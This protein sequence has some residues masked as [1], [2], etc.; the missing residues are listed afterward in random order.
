MINEIGT[1]RALPNGESLFVGSSSGVF[2]INTVR[3]AFSHA[4]GASRRRSLNDDTN[5]SLASLPSPE[6][7]IFGPESYAEAA[8]SRPTGAPSDGDGVGELPS[9]TVAKELLITYF[10]IWHPLLPFLHGPSCL[11]ELEA[12]Y[13]GEADSQPRKPGSLSMA[14][15]L[16]CLFNIAKLDRPDLPP[17]GRS[18]IGSEEQLLFSLSTLSL[19]RD[20]T[21]IQ[22]LL[23]A[24]L[25]FVAT[26]SLQAASTTGGLVLRSIFKSGLHRCPFRYSTF[27]A[28]DRDMRK[29]VI[30]SA[31]T[32]DRYTSQSLGHPLG[33]QDSDIDVCPPGKIELHKPVFSNN[34]MEEGTSLEESILHLPANHPQRQTC[35]DS[36]QVQ[37]QEQLVHERDEEQPIES[38]HS[39]NIEVESILQRR[40]RNQ[41]VQAQFVRYSRLVGR[42]IEMFHKSIHVRSVSRQDILFL[43]A[44]I[45]AWGNDMPY[46]EFAGLNPAMTPDA[47]SS[48]L[49]QD[50]FF[51]VARQQLLLLVNR[52]SLS[53]EP[54]SAEF[55][56]AVQICIGA[57][58]SIIRMLEAHFNLRETLFWPG[59]MSAVWMSG[60]VM[61]FACQLKL[62]SISNAIRYGR[63]AS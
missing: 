50:L 35:A 5:P 25:Y 33:I 49:N 47:R 37:P 57:A 34:R 6:E 58:R 40:R 60:L 23:A 10:R 41:S 61:V 32:L 4:A 56:H 26:M 52:P 19:K 48:S 42:M 29:R 44:D 9:H 28:N 62:H 59:F 53:L 51:G 7:C 18:C 17:L 15:I 43:K 12:L 20:L 31:Y 24:Q 16:R 27:S 45:D 55:R 14:I 1:L 8:W 39:Q 11:G 21:S 22:A 46:A 30:W 36:P 63:S 38:H 13:D 54:N 2:F 3:R